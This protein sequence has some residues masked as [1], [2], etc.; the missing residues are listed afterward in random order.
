MSDQRFSFIWKKLFISKYIKLWMNTNINSSIVFNLY[1][2]ITIYCLLLFVLV[3]VYYASI[4]LLR[5]TVFFLF[6]KYCLQVNFIFLILIRYRDSLNT[7]K[8]TFLYKIYFIII[9]KAF[10]NY[11]L[12][13][14][15]WFF[16]HYIWKA[17]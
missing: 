12:V 16:L 6:S 5:I 9:I 2:L 1:A 11:I 10:L 8:W 7:F 15:I 13:V 3:H 4:F 17:A 14:A